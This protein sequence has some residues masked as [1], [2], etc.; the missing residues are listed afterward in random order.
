MLS[1]LKGKDHLCVHLG[2]FGFIHFE[3][4][5]LRL[6]FEFHDLL[7]VHGFAIGLNYAVVQ[8]KCVGLIFDHV[9]TAFSDRLEQVILMQI[10]IWMFYEMNLI[11]HY[12]T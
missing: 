1:L 9:S 8:V 10:L 7:I 2:L 4:G 12:L 3:E 5:L 6:V 11:S